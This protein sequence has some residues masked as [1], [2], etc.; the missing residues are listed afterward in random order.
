M[1]FEKIT[2]TITIVP[3]I[4]DYLDSCYEYADED[5]KEI[6][7]DKVE[8]DP[9]NYR[10]SK[11]DQ[12]QK[13]YILGYFHEE[14]IMFD[15]NYYTPYI[16]KFINDVL[17]KKSHYNM[18]VIFSNSA[19]NSDI[20]YIMSNLLMQDIFEVNSTDIYRYTQSSTLMK[21]LYICYVDSFETD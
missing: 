9:V 3:F 4:T 7:K 18:F 21:S 2:S 1:S 15:D 5:V 10:I 19:D 12:Y 13:K 6:I 11:L 17:L 16:S 20:N 14:L 8:T